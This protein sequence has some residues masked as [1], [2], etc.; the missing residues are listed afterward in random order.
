[1]KKER[2]IAL[3]K[4]F[5]AESF[6]GIPTVKGLANYLETSEKT[7]RRHIQESKIFAISNTGEVTRKLD[8]VE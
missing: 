5:E 4:A 2:I 3:Q 8:K 7:V 6:G 1:M